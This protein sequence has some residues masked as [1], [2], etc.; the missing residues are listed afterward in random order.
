MVEWLAGNRIIGTTEERT[1]AT[2][3][4]ATPTK[5]IDGSYT[6]LTYTADGK[7]IPKNSFDVEYLVVAG[8]GG[9]G[10]RIGGGGGAGGYLANGAYNHAVTA[11]NYDITVGTGGA[12]GA[13]QSSGVGGQG[14]NG[15]DSSFDTI[16]ATGGGGGGRYS[17]SVANAGSTGG[18]GGGGGGN[19]SGSSGGSATAS[20]SQGNAGGTGVSSASGA[21]GGG[22][23]G[24]AG[25]NA[26]SASAGGAGGNGLQNDITGTNLY[27]AGGGAGSCDG[28]IIS[29]GSGGGGSSSINNG[30]SATAGTNGLGG[31]GGGSRGDNVLGVS[32]GSGVV[33]IRFLTS[34]NDYDVEAVGLQLRLPSGSVGGWHEIGRTK[35]GSAGNTITVSGLSDK[36]YYMLLRNNFPSGA[37]RTGIRFGS[38]EIDIDTN[39]TNRRSNNGNADATNQ[40][41]SRI[42]GDTDVVGHDF[43]VEYVANKLDKEKLFL[44]NQVVQSTAG[45]GTSPLRTEMVGKWVNT[46]NPIGIMQS[47]NTESGSFDTDSEIVVL[48]WDPEDMHTTNFWEELA[49]VEL[50]SAS[51]RIDSGTFTAKKYLW[52]QIYNTAKPSGGNSYVYFNNVV[53]GT[54]HSGRSNTN[55]RNPTNQSSQSDYQLTSSNGSIINHDVSASGTATG[56]FTNMFVINNASKEK[57]SIVTS[58]SGWTNAGAGVA[59]ARFDC[60][61]KWAETT[62]AITS[63]QCG[64]TSASTYMGAGSIIKVWGSD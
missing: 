46:T 20:P 13:S 5:I 8:G 30:G 62:D 42:V 50:T 21:G 48:G 61:G 47:V 28:A 35:L 24:V 12:G 15:S 19:A 16:T 9:G 43:N 41:T 64:S 7:F 51:M 14:T 36:R 57:L 6:V 34:G 27:Y 49:S 22:G 11:K 52:I 38:T 4:Q 60:V 25:G 54:T 56:M 32:G 59:P 23:A 39:Y 2:V 58:V 37:V 3:A 40:N 55:G 29:G 31:G 26:S 53:T 45:S 44:R 17:T 63:V 18:S 33:I 1:G 10:S